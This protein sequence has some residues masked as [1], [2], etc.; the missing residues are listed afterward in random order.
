MANNKTIEQFNGGYSQAEQYLDI[1]ELERQLEEETVK[2]NVGPEHQKTSSSLTVQKKA[3]NKD[4][5][6]LSELPTLME[7]IEKNIETLQQRLDTF[8]FSNMN[9]EQASFYRKVSEKKVELEEELFLYEEQET[10]E[11]LIFN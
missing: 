10:L 2:E 11:E 4:K 5:N 1:L 3:T 7:K 6:R 8:D 9:E